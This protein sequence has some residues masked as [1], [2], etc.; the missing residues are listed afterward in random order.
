MA[1]TAPLRCGSFSAGHEVHPSQAL[2]GMRDA[3]EPGGSATAEVVES[4]GC[5]VR[6]RLI[7][8]TEIDLYQHDP[9]S[10]T[11]LVSERGPEVVDQGKWSLLWFGKRLISVSCR[12][13][14]WRPCGEAPPGGFFLRL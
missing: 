5:R 1:A 14:T 4:A 9:E 2:R 12:R 10:V 11:A 6:I 7:D 8:G 3:K 13:A